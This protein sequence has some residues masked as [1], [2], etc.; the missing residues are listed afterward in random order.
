MLDSAIA[1]HS[2]SASVVP[3]RVRVILNASAGT[4]NKRN[5]EQLNEAIEA[6]FLARGVV[7]DV[8]AV[9]ANELGDEA[10]RVLQ[11]L[12][13]GTTDAIVVGGGDG[14][15]STVAGVMANSGY[16][17]GVLPLGTLNHFAKDLKIPLVLDEAIA[18]IAA[19]TV[20]QVDVGDANG[21]V[22]INNSSIGI[23][24]YMVIDRDRRRY[25]GLPKWLA[26]IP[27]TLRTLWNLPLRRLS[28]TIAGATVTYRSPCVFI[29]NN[30]YQLAGSSAG[31]RNRLD[32]G[33]LS[34]HVARSQGRG[35]LILLILRTMLGSLDSTND[36]KSFAVRSIK[37]NSRRKRLLVSFDGEIEIVRTP[38]S[39]AIRPGVLRIFVGTAQ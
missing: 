15:I 23:Y 4:D 11:Q 31:E 24:P 37:I 27:A 14:S 8:A 28:V 19:G 36:L 6:S 39:Y 10:A 25:S 17:M 12:K 13:D 30:E 9:T 1:A 35:A 22:F 21:R 34:L 7:A 2:G 3:K 5:S 29:G 33:N 32:R 18:T 26:M 38:L 20:R 16:A